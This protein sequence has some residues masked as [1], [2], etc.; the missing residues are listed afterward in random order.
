MVIVK[1]AKRKTRKG[2]HH[3]A[4]CVETTTRIDTRPSHNDDTSASRGRSGVATIN[5]G[6]GRGRGRGRGNVGQGMGRG[7][8]VAKNSG[9]A[10]VRGR[11]FEWV[12]KPRRPMADLFDYAR[13]CSRTLVVGLTNK[14]EEQLMASRAL[15][16]IGDRLLLVAVDQRG[17]RPLERFL[18]RAGPED[19]ATAFVQLIEAFVEL[20]PNQYASHVLES[21]LTSWPGRL[22]EKDDNDRAPTECIVK[23]CANLSEDRCWPALVSDS[24]ASHSVRALLLALGGYVPELQG[25]G[26]AAARAGLLPEKRYDTPAEIAECRRGVARSLID[27]LR[28]DGNLCLSS[29]ASPVIQLLLR[30]LRDRGDYAL[31]A[32][33]AAAVVGASSP[34]DDPCVERCDSLLRS[35]PGSR[36]LEAVLEVSNKEAST[37][38]FLKFFRSRIRALVSGEA[39]DFG[40]FLA[41]RVASTLRDEPQLMLALSQLDYE[42][43]LSAEA[44]PAQHAVV[45]RFLEACLRLR[46][47]FEKSA[48]SVFNALSLRGSRE[49]QFVWP[50][51]LALKRMESV[52]DLMTVRGQSKRGDV[53][54]EVVT[55]ADAPAKADDAASPVLRQLPAAGPQIL[56]LLI[57]FPSAAVK[58]LNH[59]LSTLIRKPNIL[60]ALAM[61][62]RTARVLEAALAPSSA[63]LPNLRAKL[64]RKFKGHLG[65]LGPHAVGGWVCAALWRASLGEPALRQA[66]AAELLAVEDSLR[67]RNFA[68]W[69]V[70]GLNQAK[71]NQEDWTKQQKKA[72]KAK[73]LFDELLEAD[74]VEAAKAANAA[75][76]REEEDAASRRALADPLVA[77]LLPQSSLD[78]DDDA[79]AA[80]ATPSSQVVEAESQDHTKRRG[81]AAGQTKRKRRRCAATAG[82][83]IYV[84]AA[85]GEEE[86]GAV[87]SALSTSASQGLP[88][89]GDGDLRDTLSLIAGRA[90]ARASERKRRKR[91]AKSK[92][93]A[94][95]SASSESDG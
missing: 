10:S 49:H 61:E 18:P 52:D 19:F 71:T 26:K 68:V 51:L 45:S 14:E 66:F 93:A 54:S 63:V 4:V 70:C 80:A 83:D 38:L 7:Q 43:C 1:V 33:A 46:C 22:H 28:S 56:G 8:N 76:V 27:L 11:G 42:T 77:S 13:S 9:T 44:T 81:N 48:A 53:E 58:P 17:S 69:K 37:A 25:K 24:C 65:E 23:L 16:E 21:A 73:R 94:A 57:R 67:S 79:I 75:R 72:S 95:T 84:E 47:G 3:G 5:S 89:G 62:A 12:E 74:S 31:A 82:D 34:Y 20:A 87:T 50:T 64:A 6:G 55:S 29:N 32:E 92:R 39:G 91:T 86:S 35:A 85:D 59:G 40:V 90:P 88:S 15:E 60:R 41:Q 2:A 30:V 78:D 36:T